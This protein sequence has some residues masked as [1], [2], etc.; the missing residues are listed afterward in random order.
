[1]SEHFNGLADR[2]VRAFRD[3]LDEQAQAAVGDEGFDQLSLLIEAHVT[4]EVLG[5]LE[6]VANEV[7][8]LASRIR[9]DAEHYT[10]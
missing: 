2:V 5:H 1:M 6:T 10:D 8:A 9:G 3:L 7:Q 4:Y